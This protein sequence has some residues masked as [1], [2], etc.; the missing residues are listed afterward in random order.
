MNHPSSRIPLLRCLSDSSDDSSA[1]ELEKVDM[2]LEHFSMSEVVKKV[3]YE[4]SVDFRDLQYRSLW[5]AHYSD[6]TTISNPLEKE[7]M[8]IG[9]CRPI[10]R[11]LD[12]L[13]GSFAS[14]QRL[15]RL[16]NKRRL[17]LQQ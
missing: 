9:L 11:K 4:K 15:M 12:F 7:R 2:L 1:P 16:Q 6:T 14:K 5:L 10:Q 8:L 3:H 17:H 13:D